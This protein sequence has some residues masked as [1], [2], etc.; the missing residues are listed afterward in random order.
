LSY[1]HCVREDP[2]RKGLLYL[3]TENALYISFNDGKNW[4]PLQNNLPHAPVHWLTIQEHF[5]DLVIGTYGR[6]FWILDDITPLQQLT[7]EVIKSDVHLFAPRQAYRFLF[8]APHVVDPRDQCR[9]E[10]PPYGAS[11]NYY[12]KTDSKDEVKISILD[13]KSRKIRTLK[14]TKKQGINR[15]WWDLR[16]EPSTELKLRTSPVG[17]PHVVVGPKGWRPYLDGGDNRGPKVIPGTYVVKLTVGVKEFTQKLIVKKDPHSVGSIEDIEAQV[18]VL[19]EIHDNMNSVAKMIN[20]IEWI[21]KQIYDLQ[22]ILEGDK[23][24]EQILNKS[25]ELDKKFIAMEENFIPLGYTGRYDRDGLRWPEKLY[26]KPASLASGIAQTDFAPTTQQKEAHE[27]LSRQFSS[28]T[29]EYNELISKDLN[30]FN[31]LLRESNIANIIVAK[32]AKK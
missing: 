8:K 19:L 5:N 25:K 14:G 2:V 29:D 17:H 31:K 10:N 12:L 11:L 20:K 9:G 27:E 6:G 28:Y 16:Y 4:I 18:K 23:N 15:I 22:E 3:G 24:A 1:A 21:R 26:E 7:P 30:D 13:E 32:V